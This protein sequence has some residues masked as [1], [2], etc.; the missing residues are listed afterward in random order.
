MSEC[1]SCPSAEH[2]GSKGQESCPYEEL[3][4]FSN[5]KHVVAVMSGK[6]G[7]GKSSV[8]VLLAREMARLGKK[9][10][11]LDADITGPSI[12]RL[13]GIPAGSH[14]Q[15]NGM[16]ILPILSADGIAVVSLNFFIAN[17]E[18]PVI[19]RG[20]MLSGAVK[21]FWT[22]VYWGELDYLFID[23]PPGTGDVVL[24]VMQSLPLSGA[25]VV[26]TPHDVASM[27]VAKSIHMAQKMG[28]HVVGVVENM[29]Y[30]RCPDCGKQIH[31]FDEAPL[32]AMLAQTHLPLLGSLPM[33]PEVAALSHGDGTQLDTDTAQ[34]L[35][36][37][38]GMLEKALDKK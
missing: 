16:G 6:G 14:C 10:G 7:V 26:S 11:I 37:I 15:Q 25:V 13:V 24:T 8:S 17:E 29:A 12:P 38:G 5:I 19:W 32:H 22:D 9:V 3:N 23:M 27:V 36:N 4:K 35:A 33:L 34:T 21:Q 2:C 28:I 18:D 30:I 1:K 20:P 31:L